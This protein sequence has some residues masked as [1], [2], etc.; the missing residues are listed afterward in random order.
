[1]PDSGDEVIGCFSGNFKE[2]RCRDE[3]EVDVKA[4]SIFPHL[5]CLRCDGSV[6]RH[7][8]DEKLKRGEG[9][10]DNPKILYPASKVR[11]RLNHIVGKRH[12]CF[13]KG[14]ILREKTVRTAF[15]AVKAFLENALSVE[16]Q[17]EGLSDFDRSKKWT[18]GVEGDGSDSVH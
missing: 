2:V 3:M 15:F 10:Y 11:L 16:G 12:L 18:A 7:I 5:Y 1:M 9:R 13:K 8:G 4:K 17:R 6:L 14:K